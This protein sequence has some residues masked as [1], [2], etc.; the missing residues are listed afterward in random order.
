MATRKCLLLFIITAAFIFIFTPFGAQ[1]P[2]ADQD[3]PMQ[4]TWMR[5]DKEYWPTG[6][7]RG[8]I[9]QTA[10]AEYIGL[11]NPYHWPVN[12]WVTIGQLYEQYLYVDGNYRANVPW[13]F[14]SWEYLDPQ[15][16]V[17]DIEKGIQF[18]DGSVLDAA[19][20]KYNME[21]ISDRK[22]G[23]WAR[24]Y[25]KHIK[26]IQVLNEYRVKWTFEK[27]WAGFIGTMNYMGYAI[28]ANA[29]RGDAALKEYEKLKK[30][31]ERA[32]AAV[33][34]A[35]KIHEKLSGTGGN[36][37]E[38]SAAKLE[39]VRKKAGQLSAELAEV[40]KLAEGARNLD[41]YPVGSG[42]YMLEEARP[43]NYLKL[44]RNPNWWFAKKIDKDM[45]YFNGMQVT[46]IPDP[47]IRLANLRAGKLDVLS[48]PK[49]QY[50][51]IKDDPNL[52][53]Y[54]VPQSNT[55]ALQ[56]NHA[57]GPCGDIRVRRAVSHAID[58]QALVTGVQ[59]GLAE[60]AAGI[61]PG[62]HYCHNP[63]LKPV[64]F[65]PSLSKKLL[66]EAGYADGLT[67]KGYAGNDTESVTRVEAI[68]G[69]LAQVGITWEVDF[70]E[71]A[72]ATDR[73]KNLEYDLASG[74]WTYIFNPD[75][76][77]TGLYH[78]EGSFN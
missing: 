41:L 42:P 4:H 26:T 62:K 71:S 78:P 36:E 16:V 33:S 32:Q 37:S 51:M 54:V 69:M 74:G 76:V 46:V 43:G 24:A 44:K 57:R 15:T 6:P 14:R 47:A 20:V 2:A 38:K 73:L 13:I 64:S 22:N 5:W 34:K 77:A 55:V 19:C 23:S 35:E 28:S 27:P 17:T 25:F 49:S 60:A 29:L 31:Y 50:N 7:V 3:R 10:A 61:Y 11:M 75:S 1:L 56:F 12:D 48:I 66:A 53:I 68:K 45:P 72:A 52:N 8:G 70:L 21:W 58:R 39:K 18:T 30:S 63:V 9:L 67:L 59:F 40:S 65:D